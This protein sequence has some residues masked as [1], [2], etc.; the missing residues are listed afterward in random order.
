[1]REGLGWQWGRNPFGA[2]VA[3]AG[4]SELRTE[5]GRVERT[6]AKGHLENLQGVHLP[7]YLP[8]DE[9]RHPAG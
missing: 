3:G 4:G 8:T 9:I 6:V 2:H 7:T 1:M 5:V